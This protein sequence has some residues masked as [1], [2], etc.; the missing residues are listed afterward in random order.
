MIN[1][2]VYDFPSS[3]PAHQLEEQRRSSRIVY[4]LST[5]ILASFVAS[6]AHNW[7]TGSA[8]ALWIM[9][10]EGVAGTIALYLNW[11]GLTNW[12]ILL[13][14]ISL[15]ATT[16]SLTARGE[17]IHDIAMLIYPSTLVAA[18]LL[19]KRRTYV[20]Y[21][22][23][24]V[25]CVLCVFLAE[26]NGI[27][28]TVYTPT[29]STSDLLDALI[30]LIMTSIIVGFLTKHLHES[31][32]RARANELALEATNNRLKQQSDHLKATEARWRS[33]V[34]NAPDVIINIGH[35]GTIE[36]VNNEEV[37]PRHSIVGKSL[38]SLVVPHHRDAM[39][40][41]IADLL[42]SGKSNTLEAQML[43]PDGEPTWYSI[44]VSPVRP[45]T[46]I[47]DVTLIARDITQRRLVEEE[48]RMLNSAL[49]HRVAERT[50]QLEAS[51]RE[52]EAFSYSV[53]HDLRAPLRH[54]VGYAQMLEIHAAGQ[55]D[56]TGRRHL[57]NIEEAAL[58]MGGLIDELLG[59]SR[60]GRVQ[61]RY[62]T[63]DME[64][65]AA[66]VRR[67][68]ENDV[69]GRSIA[70]QLQPLPSVG[71]DPALLKLVLTNLM[72]NA[73]KFTRGKDDARIQLGSLPR[74]ETIGESVFYVQDN[75]AGFDMRYVD[76]LYGVFQRLHNPSEFEGTGIG[77][78]N[79]KRIVERHGGRT[80]AE[81]VPGQGAT[82][83]FTIPWSTSASVDGNTAERFPTM[84]E[85]RVHERGSGNV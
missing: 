17:G 77:L 51:N 73:V 12:S 81:G 35:D 79:V 62:S 74:H 36:Y 6:M 20:A 43:T 9:A 19:L 7:I 14:I 3:D 49:E 27:L 53:S 57:R 15:L 8:T 80:W 46:A 68:L 23:T 52:L 50:C 58:R 32:A 54:L 59:F 82:F 84:I 24:T 18:S 65:L 69:G 37:H 75:G 11:R 76:K 16:T 66:E 26:W 72:A 63:V 4:F 22:V 78:A 5:G 34:E 55:L 85:G 38:Y 67:D 83:Y 33:L 56:E 13:L 45:G 25:L 47:T 41:A 40:A 64:Q 48:V 71:G 60:V 1:H 30:I 39:R 61:M 42:R 29:L 70:W 28:S 21:S 10:A 31:I 2:S 44:R